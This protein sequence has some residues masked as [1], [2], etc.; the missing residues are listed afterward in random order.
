MFN[1]YAKHS[2]KWPIITCSDSKSTIYW[3]GYKAV[4]WHLGS[5][6]LFRQSLNKSVLFQFLNISWPRNCTVFKKLACIQIPKTTH[7]ESQG[8]FILAVLQCVQH[9]CTQ[10]TTILNIYIHARYKSILCLK[11]KICLFHFPFS[12]SFYPKAVSSFTQYIEQKISIKRK[13]AT[14]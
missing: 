3:G 4:L 1:I 7:C 14:G 5:H 8:M 6:R 9:L 13:K 2:D 12:S 10:N 11:I